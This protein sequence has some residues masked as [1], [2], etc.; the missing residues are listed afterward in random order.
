MPVA[1]K[2]SSAMLCQIIHTFWKKNLN[3]Q[4]SVSTRLQDIMFNLCGVSVHVPNYLNKLCNITIR[5]EICALLGYNTALSGNPLLTFWDNISVPSSR[6][7]KSEKSSVC[8]NINP[9]LSS[10]E[11]QPKN[12]SCCVDYHGHLGMYLSFT[13][14][15]RAVIKCGWLYFRICHR[16]RCLILSDSTKEI[17]NPKIK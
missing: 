16:S 13:S 6:V 8:L 9:L 10:D 4:V 15:I 12:D 14:L 2:V 1:L 3:Y 7:K 11:R 5:F 17:H